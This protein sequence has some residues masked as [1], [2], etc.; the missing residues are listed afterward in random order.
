M[1]TYQSRLRQAQSY[2]QDQDVDLG[3]RLLLDC[4]IDTQDMS[5]YKR[6]IE[7]TD[8]RE[9]HANHTK[10]FITKAL[11]LSEALTHVQPDE[12]EHE[13]VVIT[14]KD[15][16][17]KYRRDGFKLGPINLQLHKSQVYGLVGENGNGKTTLLRILAQELAHDSG[18][19][20]Y[21]L[22]ADTQTNYDLR[23]RLAYVPQRT[24]QW[25]GPLMDNLKFVLAN[26]NVAPD[27]IETRALM[28]VAR[29]GLWSYK[30]LKWSELSSGYKMRFELARTLLRQPE[31]LLLDEPLANLDVLA[32]QVILEDLKSICNSP[33]NPVALILSSQQLY[34]VEKVSDRVIFL[35]KG[36]QEI[37][38]Q[39]DNA[40][41][42]Q[43]IIEMDIKATR[44]ELE[45]ALQPVG[46]QKLIF[47]GGIY[48]AYFKETTSFNQ[49][50]SILGTTQADVVYVRNISK[51]TRRFFID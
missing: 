9:H 36:S 20:D 12:H 4:T 31:V 50:L 14:A 49:V 24:E 43:L 40:D 26:Y 29:M 19:V 23:S 28:M 51:S 3:Y 41:V 16:E 35:K 15:V 44:N 21:S 34:E 48:I 46:L 22:K 10:D 42:L 45:S 18:A 5:L 11:S 2:L 39:S 37:Q 13:A 30:D 6:A 32:Q 38:E 8:W 33:V 7:L 25:Y 27:E 47:N 17:K 1:T